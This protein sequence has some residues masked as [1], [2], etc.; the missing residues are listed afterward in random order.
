MIQHVPPP[1]VLNNSIDLSS[2]SAFR[3]SLQNHPRTDITFPV[4]HFSFNGLYFCESQ[5]SSKIVHERFIEC[6]YLL[7][8][9]FILSTRFVNDEVDSFLL[10]VEDYLRVA[11][12]CGFAINRYDFDLFISKGPELAH[13]APNC[14]FRKIAFYKGADA[15]MRFALN[16]YKRQVFACCSAL[17]HLP[18]LVTLCIMDE[19][20][21]FTHLIAISTRYAIATAAKHF[22][23]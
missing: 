6:N 1:N 2:A 3:H 19:L 16:V 9:L 21:E 15:G 5:F 4:G 20:S 18:A 7:E 12:E 11:V 23:L 13:Q 22:C 14:D 8:W 10:I 17:R